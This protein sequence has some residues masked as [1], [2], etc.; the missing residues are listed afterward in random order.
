LVTTRKETTLGTATMQVM[1]RLGAT[2]K[3]DEEAL[4][5]TIEAV[6]ITTTIIVVGMAANSEVNVAV[7]KNGEVLRGRI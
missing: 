4:G 1:H 7:G 3:V 5:A 6:G 2:F